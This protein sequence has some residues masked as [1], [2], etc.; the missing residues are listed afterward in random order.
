MNRTAWTSVG[1]LGVVI[2]CLPASANAQELRRDSVWNGV[3]TGAAVG[4][5]LGVVVAKTTEDICSAPVC[6]S[7]L[8]VVG[9]ALGHL[10]DAMRGERAPVVP[11][12]WIDDSR[13]NG[14]LIGA[15]AA[16]AV[17]VIDLARVCGTGPRQV[18][19]TTGGTVT[20]LWRAA[21]FG[22]AIGALVDAAIPRRVAAGAGSATTRHFSVAFHIRF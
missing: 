14:A 19:C 17:L 18:Q 15:G 9:G 16:S 1:A 22:A 5:G 20:K 6:A 2:V 7:L 12:Q 3:V 10:T 4:A 21:L 11:G 8:A 13:A